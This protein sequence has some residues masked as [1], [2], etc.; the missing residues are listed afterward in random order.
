MRALVDVPPSLREFVAGRMVG[1]VHEVDRLSEIVR[2]GHAELEVS[3]TLSRRDDLL[4]QLDAAVASG[5]DKTMMR[6]MEGLDAQETMDIADL[7]DL[8]TRSAPNSEKDE[9]AERPS[10]QWALKSC[11]STTPDSRRR[12]RR[13]RESHHGGHCP[14]IGRADQT[15]GSQRCGHMMAVDTFVEIMHA[16]G[17]TDPCGF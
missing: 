2:S 17:T 4:A 9:T 3:H 11:A 1:P 7:K 13:H 12:E 8:R 6:V 5:D 10:Y 14:F 16:D 15:I